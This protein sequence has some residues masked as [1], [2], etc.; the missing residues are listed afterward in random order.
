LDVAVGD[1]EVALKGEVYEVDKR[2][3]KRCS[4]AF[5]LLGGLLPISC[6]KSDVQA[7]ATSVACQE[8]TL[9]T[10]RF[11]EFVTV[12]VPFLVHQRM[13]FADR[14]SEG[15]VSKMVVVGREEYAGV[16]VILPFPGSGDSMAGSWTLLRNSRLL[17]GESSGIDAVPD[18][19]E[20]SFDA[21]GMKIPKINLG[22]LDE[23]KPQCETLVFEPGTKTF[24]LSTP[25]RTLGVKA[26]S[27][28]IE[29]GEEASDLW[30]KLGVSV[31]KSVERRM[32]CNAQ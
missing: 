5:A 13:I 17:F 26:V 27:L 23:L 32:D 12:G 29:E 19:W 9:L 25:D 4:L 7:E 2:F 31:C 22:I 14:D 21:S 30:Q 3:M 8:I 28:N 10:E 6:T 24:S 1:E 16:T 18:D 15:S 11:E 20:S